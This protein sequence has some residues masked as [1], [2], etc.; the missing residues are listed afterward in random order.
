[1]NKNNIIGIVLIGIIMI[2]FSYFTRPSQLEIEKQNHYRDSI[3]EVYKAQQ[4]IAATEQSQ[5][6]EV[7][8]VA[9]TDT[10][11]TTEANNNLLFD[12]YGVFANNAERENS[13]ITL[14]NDKI[15]VKISSK[16][17]RVYSVELKE[18]TTYTKL[19]LILFDGDNTIFG[20]DFFANNRRIST[21]ELYFDINS[22]EEN[23]VV[24]GQDST[25]LSLRLNAGEGSYIEYLY[26]LKGDGYNLDFNVNLVKMNNLITGNN[27][28]LDLTWQFDSPQQEK[29]HKNENNYTT[30]SYRHA[31]GE[32][33]KITPTSKEGN[34]EITTKLEWVAFKDQF[35]SSILVA[36]NHLSNTK[37]NTTTLEDGSGYV[38]RF[39]AEM[40]IAY[41]GI[42]DQNIPFNFYFGPNQFS[43]LKKQGKAFEELVPLGW[44]IFGWV[45]RW[46]VIPTFNFLGSWVGIGSMGLIILLLTIFIKLILFPLTYKSYQSSAKMRLLKPEIDEISKKFPKKEDAMKKQQATMGLYKKAGANPMGGCIPM[47]VQMPIIIAMF[48]F[49]PAAFELRQ[50]S[51]LWADDLSSF[52]AIISWGGDIPLISSMFG[53]HISLFTLLM[54]IALFFS[55]KLN[56]A[57]MGDANAQMPGMKFMMTWGMP[58]MMIFWF[59]NYA[60]GLSYYY[61]L[62]NVIT[63]GQTMI[64]RYTLDEDKLFKKLQEN[65]KKPVK[66]SK[67]QARMEE[68]A[69]QRGTSKK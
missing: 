67:F 20:F 57:Q 35:F 29:G 45:N 23:I 10:T 53:N 1:M 52:D 4:A 18:F 36:E 26:S 42:E 60:S 54:A 50:K 21:N 41:S 30:I 2:G 65:K 3:A 46:I 14:E 63:I 17:G 51:F 31:E 25:S 56:S 39:K 44:T 58:I 68:M 7:I 40:G 38:K 28:I 5:N 43:T 24:T 37:L 64:F 13:F 6:K 19:P 27:S 12:K 33:D 15:K 47:L 55:T 34:E 8:D 62:S 66:K 61:F 9:N 16:G 22:D 48:S 11:N 32:V 69:K 59:N 49:F